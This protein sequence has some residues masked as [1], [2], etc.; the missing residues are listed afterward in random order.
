MLTREYNYDEVYLRPRKCQ[1]QSRSECDIKVALGPKVFRNP[2]IAANMKS[3]VDYNTCHY[4]ANKGMFYI[5][6]RFHLQFDEL[7][8]FILDSQDRH[9]FASISVGIQGEDKDV[10]AK[11]STEGARPEYITIDVAH[12]HSD[13]TLDMIRYIKKLL[14]DCFLIVG[15]VAT[16]E[17]VWELSKH[18]VDAIKLFIA[19]G[20]AC[21]TKVKTGF[22]R[23]TVTCLQECFEVSEN[24]PLIA[25]GG[26]REPGHIAIAMACGARMVMVGSYMSGFDQNS[27]DVVEI[28]GHKKY[29]YYGSASFNNKKSKKHVEG[30]EIILDY[31]GSMDD[32]IYDIECSLRSAISYAGGN[33]LSDLRKVDKFY[34]E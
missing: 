15:N 7:K 11:L 16:S 22:T 8:S 24:I 31:K 18:E 30:K 34:M 20:A 1:V 33:K 21:T 3:V 29:I 19:P 5:M 2:V 13:R 17:S 6:H 4:L 9:G 32:H 12:A 10:L 25:D 14:P 23:G 26:I 27:G 28:N